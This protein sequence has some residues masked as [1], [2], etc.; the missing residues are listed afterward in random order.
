[1]MTIVF[2]KME[3][4]AGNFGVD[5]QTIQKSLDAKFNSRKKQVTRLQK[6]FGV[7]ELAVSSF[8]NEDEDSIERSREEPERVGTQ[9]NFSAMDQYLYMLCQNMVDNVCIYH[10]RKESLHEQIELGKNYEPK[11][12]EEKSKDV[13]ADLTHKLETLSLRVVPKGQR[14][15]KIYNIPVDLPNEKGLS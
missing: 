3:A 12:E 5:I 11:D 15:S 6:D 2:Q 4:Y 13:V 7:T 14:K 1:M 9:I 8:F 10:K